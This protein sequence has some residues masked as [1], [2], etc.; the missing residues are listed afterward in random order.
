MAATARENAA[1]L[2][3]RQQ[4]FHI[5]G[6]DPSS[7]YVKRQ[8]LL[9][10][11]VGTLFYPQIC[12]GNPLSPSEFSSFPDPTHQALIE[13]LDDH[14]LVLECAFAVLYASHRYQNPIPFNVY[15]QNHFLTLLCHTLLR[16]PT[17]TLAPS[18][19][20]EVK[21]PTVVDDTHL[22]REETFAIFSS[23]PSP[24]TT[25]TD[26]SM[27][28]EWKQTPRRPTTDSARQLPF[29]TPNEMK[30][31]L[32]KMEL[33]DQYTFT[34]LPSDPVRPM[35]PIDAAKEVKQ[36]LTDA[37]TFKT[38]YDNALS[39]REAE[40]SLSGSTMSQGIGKRVPWCMYKAIYRDGAK[41][42]YAVFYKATTRKRIERRSLASG[43]NR[44]AVNIT[45]DVLNIAPV[46]RVCEEVTGTPLEPE[47]A[48]KGIFTEQQGHLLNL[49]LKN[50]WPMKEIAGKFSDT[51][52]EFVKHCVQRGTL[53]A[54]P[55]SLKGVWDGFIPW[56]TQ[57]I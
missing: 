10:I 8:N 24:N 29:H 57:E 9:K 41:E 43:P 18:K 37:A 25:P 33:A 19:M 4:D 45:H 27:P 12:R 32:T 23:V 35:V 47:D 5:I 36:V 46:H 55:C 52:I 44:G 14:K 21:V 48:P 30:I 22:V 34:P 7:V 13:G 1:K 3:Q 26:P 40:G 50:E 2:K 16:L 11:C 28:S 15:S 39:S 54:D 42:R 31:W 20:L 56:M 51:L 53:G 49:Q 17:T 6:W 38:T